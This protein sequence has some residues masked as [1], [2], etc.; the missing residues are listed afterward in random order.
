MSSARSR[1]G[2]GFAGAVA[3]ALL[4][5]AAIG[6]TAPAPDL[7]AVALAILLAVPAG[8]A[9]MAIGVLASTPVRAVGWLCAIA[10][11]L[12]ACAGAGCCAA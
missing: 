9:G 4:T 2:I 3:L 5:S 1:L 11:G 8:L 6:R 7:S 10:I 12:A